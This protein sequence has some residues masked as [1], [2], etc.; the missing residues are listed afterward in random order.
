M[1]ILYVPYVPRLPL[2]SIRLQL[3]RSLL[4]PL[5]QRSPTTDHFQASCLRVQPLLFIPAPLQ[6]AV[7]LD[8]NTG[9]SKMILHLCPTVYH[10]I[11]W[12]SQPTCFAR[13]S[14]PFH[15]TSP[16]PHANSTFFLHQHTLYPSLGAFLALLFPLSSFR[17]S[18]SCVP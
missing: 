15:S 12:I 9:K 17:V 7:H 16:C 13:S 14:L 3:R 10:F 2:P 5:F 18:G 4:P 8:R 1:Y 6:P 11:S